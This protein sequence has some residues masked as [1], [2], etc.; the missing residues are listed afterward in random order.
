MQFVDE[1]RLQILA[2]RG[3]AAADLDVLVAGGGL[4]LI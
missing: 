2:H 1:A 4:R 3:D